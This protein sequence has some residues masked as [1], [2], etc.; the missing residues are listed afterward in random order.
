MKIITKFFLIQ[1]VI[2][3]SFGLLLGLSLNHRKETVANTKTVYRK[4][5]LWYLG[6]FKDTVNIKIPENAKYHFRTSRGS[7]TLVF[8]TKEGYEYSEI[9]NVVN[10]KFLD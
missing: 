8:D 10:V 5:E 2:F 9:Q 4:V 7:S 3:I 1:I 6:G